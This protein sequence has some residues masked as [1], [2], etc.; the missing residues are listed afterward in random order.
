MIYIIIYRSEG[1]GSQT[2][3][4]AVDA[5]HG[6]AGARS[7]R[8]SREYGRRRT[9]PGE[10]S[11]DVGDGCPG[12]G[13]RLDL[14]P[15]RGAVGE[16][17]RP[18]DGGA[19]ARR[20]SNER[21]RRHSVRVHTVLHWPRSV[22]HDLAKGCPTRVPARLGSDQRHEWVSRTG[23]RRSAPRDRRLVR[24]GD[25]RVGTRV[26]RYRSGELPA[27]GL[28]LCAARAESPPLPQRLPGQDRGGVGFDPG[29]V[30][31]DGRVD[32]RDQPNPP[33]HATAVDLPL[34]RSRPRAGDCQP[35]V[36]ATAPDPA[37]SRSARRERR[38]HRPAGPR[39]GDRTD[40][41]WYRRLG[42][43]GSRRRRQ[44]DGQIDT[45]R[46]PGHRALRL[47]YRRRRPDRRGERPLRHRPGRASVARAARGGVGRDAGR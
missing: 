26:S 4:L 13:S 14:R 23:L 25:L 35:P 11:R 3:E 5:V 8:R 21:A 18:E 32:A 2:D 1:R 28:V 9:R 12:V 38:R 34:R 45:R 33:L 10:P 44:P 6:P 39:H 30:G 40:R 46:G 15:P 42:R 43:R 31:R 7:Y 24:S 37:R 19:D 29:P 36:R 17:V 20:S 16:D 22:A 27:H 47:R 41:R